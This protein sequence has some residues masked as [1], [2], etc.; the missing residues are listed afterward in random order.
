MT[1]ATSILPNTKALRDLLLELMQ[2]GIDIKPG[3]PWAPTPERPA[4]VALYVDD[5]TKLKT[6]VFC[7]LAL[8]AYL[9]ACIGLVPPGGAKACVED[10]KLSPTISDNLYEVFN[11]VS[12]LFNV[13]D[14]PHLKLYQ[15]HDPGDAL[16]GDVAAH[17]RAMGAR[18]D[19]E[20]S[21]AGYGSG[22]LSIVLI[23]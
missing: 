22:S 13:P 16:P 19:L 2:K 4:A 14:H 15:V 1:T 6:L 11:I 21:V 17:C 3:Q 9:G 5:S 7:D 20:V 12:A 18:D 8:G 23:V 10:G